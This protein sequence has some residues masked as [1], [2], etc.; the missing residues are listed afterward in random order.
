M[1]VSDFGECGRN[2]SYG[3]KNNAPCIFLKLNKIYGWVPEYYNDTNNLP[4][5]MPQTLKNHIA[6]LSVK[7][8]NQVWVSCQGEDGADKE[9]V[10][11]IEYFP[12]RGFPS[13]FYPYLN[14]KNYVSPLV[15]VRFRRLGS[16]HGNFF[17]ITKVFYSCISSFSYFSFFP[18]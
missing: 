9:N 5:D 2:N 16:K 10:R 15:A 14:V 3:Y 4:D 7:E 12:T 11:T 13:Y 6:S 8:R 18:Q 17:F 1:D